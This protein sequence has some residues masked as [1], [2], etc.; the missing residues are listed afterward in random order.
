MTRLEITDGKLIIEVEGADKLWALKSSLTIPLAH[1]S[2]V[3]HDPEAAG[4]WWHG[5]KAPGT[6]L[7]GVVTAGTFYRAGE[8]VF[9]DVHHPENTIIITLHDES[10]QKLVIEVADPAAA[11]SQILEALRAS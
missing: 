7:P 2:S 5:I 11:T 8:K 1:I 3:D 9:W 6:N 10:Y 4:K